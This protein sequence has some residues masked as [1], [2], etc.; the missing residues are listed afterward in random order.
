MKLCTFMIEMWLFDVAICEQLSCENNNL[1]AKTA[2][3]L[4]SSIFIVMLS[5]Y[6]FKTLL[7]DFKRFKADETKKHERERLRMQ[8][9]RWNFIH[10]VMRI[11][12]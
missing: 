6:T 1:S 12:V 5:Y 9:G 7:W 2:L 8:R 3:L 4:S 11:F 10:L